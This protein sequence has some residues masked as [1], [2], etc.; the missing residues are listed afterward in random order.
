[1]MITVRRE[2]WMTRPMTATDDRDRDGEN[3]CSAGM[4]NWRQSLQ[5]PTIV[6]KE[7]SPVNFRQDILSCQAGSFVIRSKNIVNSI[8]EKYKAVLNLHS[9]RFVIRLVNSTKV[10]PWFASEICRESVL[11][12]ALAGTCVFERICKVMAQNSSSGGLLH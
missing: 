9:K 11:L 5:K 12:P 8:F 4:K 1:M 2:V 3:K 7:W 6:N 10:L